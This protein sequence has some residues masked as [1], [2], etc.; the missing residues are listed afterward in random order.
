MIN[1]FAYGSNLDET[2]MRERCP[3]SILVGKFVL[4][5][6]QLAFTTFSKRRECGCADIVKSPGDEVWGLVYRFTTDDLVRMDKAE[7]HPQKYRRFTTSVE[8]SAG[9]KVAAETYEVVEK[10]FDTLAP[11]QEYLQILMDAAKKYNFP[12]KYRSELLRFLSLD[13]EDLRI[14]RAECWNCKKEMRIAFLGENTSPE[15]FGEE[16]IGLAK[17]RGVI[18]EERYSKTRGEAYLANI[19]PHCD[20]MF[21]DWFLPDYWYDDAIEYVRKRS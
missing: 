17:S 14:V 18:I 5:D 9:E 11:S 19:C 20:E 7:G 8:N 10:S 16:D 13:K 3:G 4:K 1:Y 15:G 12:E 2:Q 21:G 6:Y